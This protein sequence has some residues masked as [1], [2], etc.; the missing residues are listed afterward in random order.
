MTHKLIDMLQYMRPQGSSAQKYFCQKFL[1]PVFGEPDAHGN[2]I[3]HVGVKPRLCFAS[4]HDTVHIKEGM[5]NVVVTNNII[6]VADPKTSS[7]L[8]ADCT[9]GI[10]IMLNMIEEGIEGTY[11]VHAAEEVGCVGSKAL[12]SD[13]PEWLSH[14]DAVISFDRY[15]TNSVITHQMGIRTASDSFAKSF[16]DALAMPT[17]KADDGGSYTDSNEYAAV[18]FECTNI[19]VGYYKQHTTNETQDLD[20]AESLL[21]QILYADWTKISISRDPSTYEDPWYDYDPMTGYS[22]YNRNTSDPYNVDDLHTLILDYPDRVAKFLDAYN[23][24]ADDIRDDCGIQDDY[25]IND[26]VSRKFM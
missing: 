5:Q 4:H 24:T 22:Y 9:T 7:C 1:D 10:W 16:A 26:Y 8:G 14:T 20:F 25:Y 3:H 11:V 12:V 6:S 15:G 21:L 2:Y 17:L 18:I 19:S 23:F 13:N